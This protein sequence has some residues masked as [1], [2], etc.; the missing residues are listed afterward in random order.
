MDYIQ[1]ALDGRIT[2]WT[3][4]EKY[5]TGFEQVQLPEG[6]EVSE[7]Q[8]WI[9][10]NGEWTYDPLPEPDPPEPTPSIEERVA[11]IEDEMTALTSAFEVTE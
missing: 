2:G 4:D 11:N 7:M 10:S 8:D 9:Y 6:F 3:F 5:A 1:T